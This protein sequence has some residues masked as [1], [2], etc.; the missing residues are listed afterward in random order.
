MEEIETIIRAVFTERPVP[1][2][3]F[4]PAEALQQDMPQELASRIEGRAW[5]SLSLLDWRGVG[6]PPASYRRYVVP[7]TFAYYVPSL[8]VGVISEPD[9][10]DLALEA[11]LPDNRWR[12]PRGEWWTSFAA[13]FTN[14]QRQAIRAFLA[15][16]REAAAFTFDLADEDLVSAAE[17]VWA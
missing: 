12:S 3:F 9:F 11:I 4:G 16:Q 13:T 15:F 6:A 2:T 5:T 10:R 14:P 8:L 7:K 17:K 1:T